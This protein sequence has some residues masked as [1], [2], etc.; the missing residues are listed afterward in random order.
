MKISLFCEHILPR[1][2]NQ[3]SE[4]VRLQDS[5][6]TFELADKVGFH[7]VWMTEHHFLEEYCH[8]TAPE[9]FLAAVSQR[10]KNLR[11][12]FG[13]MH[14]LP[15]V[16]H[17]ARVAERVSVLD[18]VSNGRV[19]FGTGEGS[20]A[21][22][23]EGFDLDPGK[24]REMWDEGTK[25]AIRC[26]VE[27]PFTGF[28]GEHVRMPPRNVV[29]KP[30]QK[31][32]PPVWVACTQQ[33]TITMAGERG[34]GALGFS[35]AGPDKFKQRVE[36]YY[37]ALERAVP[38]GYAVN[39]NILASAGQMMCGP[40]DDASW[41]MIADTGGFF[42][43]GIAHYYLQGG[44]KPAETNLWDLYQQTLQENPDAVDRSRMGGV[45]SVE[46]IRDF[47]R[48]YEAVGVD[49]MMF[50]LPP[51][52]NELILESIERFGREVLPEFHE[53][54]EQLQ[55]AKQKRLEP[56][57]EAAMARRVDDAPPMPEG[58]EIAGVPHSYDGV[59]LTEIR[60]TMAKIAAEQAEIEKQRAAQPSNA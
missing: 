44:H 41:K 46:K 40:T 54:D 25:V 6:E 33:D 30:R 12:G 51:V 52:R 53:R 29:P 59:P 35:F 28:E 43:F 48:S 50:L 16:N 47:I 23:L 57:I 18:L 20:S 45:G 21:S 38:M 7:A 4:Y 11:L 36:Q 34:L 19:E 42:G 17:P 15:K 8:S 24:K 2:W 56:V 5:L 14:T 49:Q 58:Y 10:T 9:V 39:A 55:A 37:S 31:P 27:T 1:P 3:D 26:M 60:D 32:H 13:I 22:E